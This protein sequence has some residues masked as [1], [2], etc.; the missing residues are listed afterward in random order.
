VSREHALSGKLR[1]AWLPTAPSGCYGRKA[2]DAATK[3][4]QLTF[5]T[6]LASLQVQWER[7]LLR[8]GDKKTS[9]FL[10]GPST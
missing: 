7:Y 5:M 3:F 10:A 4:S 9:S 2:S 6:W 8:I 1:C